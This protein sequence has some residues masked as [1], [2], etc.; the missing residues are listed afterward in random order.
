ML[1]TRAYNVHI[2]AEDAAGNEIKFDEVVRYPGRAIDVSGRVPECVR[3]DEAVKQ[4]QNRMPHLKNVHAKGS[5]H[6]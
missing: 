5:I 2:V 4:V 1:S 3:E 6:I